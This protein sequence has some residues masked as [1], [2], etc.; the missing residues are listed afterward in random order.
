MSGHYKTNTNCEKYNQ[1]NKNTKTNITK[2]EKRFEKKKHTKGKH[3][4]LLTPPKPIMNQNNVLS[5]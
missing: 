4:N 2:I 1:Y 3:Q 5:L